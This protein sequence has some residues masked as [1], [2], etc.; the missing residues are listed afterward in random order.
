LYYLIVFV[1]SSFQVICIIFVKDIMLIT[2][3]VIISLPQ[4]LIVLLFK[5]KIQM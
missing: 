1:L 3:Q 2:D 5:N 4:K